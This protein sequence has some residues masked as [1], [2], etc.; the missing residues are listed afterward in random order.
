MRWSHLVRISGHLLICLTEKVQPLIIL[1]KYHGILIQC[2]FPFKYYRKKTWSILSSIWLQVL[3]VTAFEANHGVKNINWKFLEP[4]SE[5]ESLQYSKMASWDDQDLHLFSSMPFVQ[6]PESIV[7]P[8][9]HLSYEDYPASSSREKSS[10]DYISSDSL[11]TSSAPDSYGSPSNSKQMTHDEESGFLANNPRIIKSNGNYGSKMSTEH[12]KG[13]QSHLDIES[14]HKYKEDIQLQPYPQMVTYKPYKEIT[15]HDD[16]EETSRQFK[17]VLTRF[18]PST[19]KK[20]L[21]KNGNQHKVSS[22]NNQSSVETHNSKKTSFHHKDIKSDNISKRVDEL[23]IA[24]HVARNHAAHHTK[25]EM[26]PRN[27]HSNR[28]GLIKVLLDITR[29]LLAALQERIKEKNEVE[30][31]SFPLFG[32]LSFLMLLLNSILLIIQNININNTNNNNNN[33]NN[34][35]D[36]NNNNN[37]NNN[38]GRRLSSILDDFDLGFNLDRVCTLSHST[39]FTVM[40]KSRTACNYV[41]SINFIISNSLHYPPVKRYISIPKFTVTISW[42]SPRSY[43]VP[44]LGTLTTYLLRS[45]ISYDPCPLKR[46]SKSSKCVRSMVNCV[47]PRKELSAVSLQLLKESFHDGRKNLD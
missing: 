38:T 42:L 5:S 46:L 12:Y 13:K 14:F 3:F 16:G 1:H 2:T 10:H 20:D 44:F 22:E 26:T 18:T 24:N 31:R 19:A 9:E 34:N 23:V 29:T 39:M 37:N 30:S 17:D 40:H 36:N 25:N 33:N 41:F 32:F 6:F 45:L 28:F 43:Q 11:I 15:V 35:N 47:I 7:K 27:E 4:S 21:M 8:Q